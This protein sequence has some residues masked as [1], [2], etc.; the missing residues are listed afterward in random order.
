V[1]SRPREERAQRD[2]AP[3]AAVDGRLAR[4]EALLERAH[5]PALVRAELFERRA[6]G[7][8][9]ADVAHL[10]GL[11]VLVP[12]QPAQRKTLRAAD[13]GAVLVD[14]AF[15]AVVQER[16]AS[17]LARHSCREEL[18]VMTLDHGGLD[19]EDREPVGAA[20]VTPGAAREARTV[21]GRDG[22]HELV[23]DAVEALDPVDD[24]GRD[25]AAR[26]RFRGRHGA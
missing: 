23:H 9:R 24:L 7:V 19:L 10:G 20:I 2:A 3:L 18:G 14:A 21:C 16:A 17:L 26:A 4:R 15:P 8:E 6:L 25:L 13:V 12:L 5:R 22:R 1:P 11:T